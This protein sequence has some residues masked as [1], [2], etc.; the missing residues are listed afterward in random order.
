MNES[1][2]QVS[3]MIAGIASASVEQ[4]QGVNEINQAI[5]LIDNVTHKTPPWLK[6]PQ[7][8]LKA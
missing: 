7:R 5:G 3:K 6:K 2:A 4:A 1:I 8:R